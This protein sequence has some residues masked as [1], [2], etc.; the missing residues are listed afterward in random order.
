MSIDLGNTPVGTPPTE[1]EKT[2]LRTSFGLGATDTV[3][4]AAIDSEALIFQEVTEAE[5]LAIPRTVGSFLVS[6]NTKRAF[7]W[8]A[9]ATPLYIT[10][11]D[12]LT[13]SVN[14]LTGN[15]IFGQAGSVAFKTIGAAITQAIADYPGGNAQVTVELEAG[16]YDTA[17]GTNPQTYTASVSSDVD[18]FFKINEGALI[19]LSVTDFIDNTTGD[20]RVRS[21]TG[22]A[23]VSGLLGTLYTGPSFAGGGEIVINIPSFAIPTVTS[24][25]NPLIVLTGSQ[26]FLRLNLG[27]FDVVTILSS[28]VM[29]TIVDVQAGSAIIDGFKVSGGHSALSTKGTIV[30][31]ASGASCKL[32]NCIGENYGLATQSATD[33]QVTLENCVHYSGR[34]SD[35]IVTASVAATDLDILWNSASNRAVGANTSVVTTFGALT[36]ADTSDVI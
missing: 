1:G 5:A 20:I 32:I 31:V 7:F 36:I 19:V 12:T 21:I 24:G 2:Q 22:S 3:E 10:G 25:A 23:Q 4:F 28:T 6:S 9:S 30:T 35:A 18:F 8:G 13:Y 16:V 11:G 34:T 17:D 14:P 26:S 29:P 27:S 33:A 15:D